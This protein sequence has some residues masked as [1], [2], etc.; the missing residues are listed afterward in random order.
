MIYD[1]KEGSHRKLVRFHSQVKARDIG[2]MLAT[3]PADAKITQATWNLE[4]DSLE[5]MLESNEFP[6]ESAGNCFCH[7][8]RRVL[9]EG[10]FD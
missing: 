8:S 10:R 5:L 2:K 3:L 9:I 7:S 1:H 4:Y 6:I